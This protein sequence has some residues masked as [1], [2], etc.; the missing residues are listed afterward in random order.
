MLLH[1][2]LIHIQ[3]QIKPWLLFGESLTLSLKAPT[4][5][6]DVQLPYPTTPDLV[7]VSPNA[8]DVQWLGRCVPT[9][10]S[11]SGVGRY[12]ETS[13]HGA[14]CFCT[15]VNTHLHYYNSILGETL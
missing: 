4:H 11:P 13:Q 5:R 10:K 3:S 6:P 12:I 15:R 9:L 8:S 14:I 1:E 7:R 2:G